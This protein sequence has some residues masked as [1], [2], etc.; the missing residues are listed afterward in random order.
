MLPT[1]LPAPVRAF[2]AVGAP[3]PIRLRPPGIELPAPLA[4]LWPVAILAETRR[5][6]PLGA[7][8]PVSLPGR[9]APVE[10]VEERRSGLDQ[11]PPGRVA[12]P[13]AV[14]LQGL[15]AA[16]GVP[17]PG[18]L[19]VPVVVP[20]VEATGA[21]GPKAR[22]PMV[23]VGAG[24]ASPGP[25][26]RQPGRAEAQA[27]GRAWS[28]EA[29]QARAEIAARAAEAARA[30]IARADILRAEA[31]RADI[32]RAEARAAEGW[33]EVGVGAPVAPSQ[34]EAQRYVLRVG[35]RRETE[36][37]VIRSVEVRLCWIPDGE[38]WMGSFGAGRDAAPEE[39]PATRVEV[40]RGFWMMEVPV[41]Q[42][43]YRQIM[44]INPSVFTFSDVAPVEHL[45][46][47]D[48][49]RFA[50]EMGRRTGR[51]WRLPTEGEWEW[52]ARGG[53]EH[54]YAGADD[55]QDVAWFAANSRRQ[56]R[57]VRTK[58]PNGFGLYDMCGNVWE[59]T[60]SEWG[61]H[62]PGGAQV[63]PAAV[64][65]ASSGVR[66]VCRGG[67]WSGD[68]RGVRLTARLRAEPMRREDIIGFR[69]CAEG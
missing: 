62:L 44:G 12:W 7:A 55:P 9:Q 52:A 34:V 33:L 29:Q 47:R 60:A 19:D 57:P 10:P 18:R 65:P 66:R 64:A 13:N 42:R 1:S 3:L 28:S 15:G 69:L 50:E 41:T 8:L 40:P 11:R 26:E 51:Q 25:A 20:A 46:W 35:A 2:G 16:L 43:L 58:R 63:E 61:D 30:E 37:Q 22:E 59:W 68:A 14:T 31:A 6:G 24:D 54:R 36:V 23:R 4:S 45:T 56:S 38:F 53:E 49:V 5:V 39:G 21:W 32:V 17:E 27:G 48:A 67:C